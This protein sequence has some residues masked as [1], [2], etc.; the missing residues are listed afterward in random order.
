ML[1]DLFS[2]FAFGKFFFIYFKVLLTFPYTINAVNATHLGTC[3]SIIIN[4]LN[5]EGTEIALKE[6]IP[7]NGA[8]CPP[9]IFDEVSVDQGETTCPK[10]YYKTADTCCKF[11]QGTHP[12]ILNFLNHYLQLKLN[13][14]VKLR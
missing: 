11:L 14:T 1:D 3:N 2:Q 13:N 4:N 8:D 5:V 9:V 10:P 12:E 6:P 7:G